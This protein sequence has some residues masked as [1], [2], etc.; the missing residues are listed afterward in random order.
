MSTLNV[1]EYQDILELVCIAS[2]QS[3]FLISITIRLSPWEIVQLE[4]KIDT[5]LS[6]HVYD[7]TVIY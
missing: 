3:L 2:C 1:L 7:L 5:K 6:G 4:K